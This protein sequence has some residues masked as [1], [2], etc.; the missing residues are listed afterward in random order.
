VDA[1]R[2]AAAGAGPLGFLAGQE[3][4]QAAGLNALQIVQHAHAVFGAV[5]L[6]EA[7]QAFAGK[8]AAA[9]AEIATPLPAGLDF[10]GHAGLALAAVVAPAAGARIPAALEGEA[11]PAIH[12][13]RGH[14]GSRFAFAFGHFPGLHPGELGAAAV[15]LS[16]GRLEANY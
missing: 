16:S 10:A 9:G 15:S 11:E 7:A 12:A 4:E 5:T 3:A 14:Q 2:F 1:Q 13:A 8:V 6:V